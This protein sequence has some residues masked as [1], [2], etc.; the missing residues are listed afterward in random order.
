MFKFNK[1]CNFLLIIQIWCWLKCIRQRIK[2]LFRCWCRQC[3]K[4]LITCWMYHT[5]SNVS[6]KSCSGYLQR[7]KWLTSR[8]PWLSYI[9]YIVYLISTGKKFEY[10]NSYIL[11]EVSKYCWTAGFIFVSVIEI[12]DLTKMLLLHKINTL[13]TLHWYRFFYQCKLTDISN[14]HGCCVNCV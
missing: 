14:S 11:N 12:I 7:C 8:K 3:R 9:K 10:N 5:V 13:T 4:E 6:R 2:Q 1:I